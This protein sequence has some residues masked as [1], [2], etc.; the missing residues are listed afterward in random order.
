MR[1]RTCYAALLCA[2]AALFGTS[3]A[4]GHELPLGDGKISTGPKA[5]YVY[6]C[7]TQFSGAAELAAVRPVLP[8]APPPR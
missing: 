2:G 3:V 5:G 1:S 7:Q 6:S 4:L 8:Q